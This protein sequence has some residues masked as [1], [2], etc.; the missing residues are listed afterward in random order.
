M[1]KEA[2]SG[3]DVFLKKRYDLVPNLVNTVKGYTPHETQLL[4]KI[5]V[6]RTAA[7]Q[8]TS[9]NQ[10]ITT[11][12]ELGNEIG[13]V[14]VSAENYTDLKANISFLELQTRL[15]TIEGEIEMSRRYYNGTVRENNI[16]V[17]SF[18]ANLIARSFK[19]ETGLF[20]E[21]EDIQQRE[22]INVSF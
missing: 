9:M 20:Y 7:M 10:R 8:S 13:Q 18:P 21:I 1:M 14:F 19:F 5:T 12:N 22:S 15:A 4:E 11:E 3:I 6:L 2:W 16:A 17:E